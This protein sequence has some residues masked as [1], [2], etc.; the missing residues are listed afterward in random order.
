MEQMSSHRHDLRKVSISSKVDL[1]DFSRS[2]SQDWNP[3]RN[4]CRLLAA[5]CLLPIPDFDINVSMSSLSFNRGLMYLILNW[6]ERDETKS[7]TDTKRPDKTKKPSVDHPG[8]DPL[9][10]R[11]AEVLADETYCVRCSPSHWPSVESGKLRIFT[12]SIP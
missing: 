10:L 8:A 12:E 4:R 11:S 3:C 9:S 6:I 1:R 7:Q 5:S 2:L